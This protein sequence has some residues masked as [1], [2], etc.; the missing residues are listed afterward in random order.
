M[1]KHATA[2]LCVVL[3]G[4]SLAQQT[5]KELLRNIPGGFMNTG[6]Y[7]DLPP[8]EQY[9]YAM[10]FV[11]GMMASGN[12]GADISKLETLN[13][14]T[15]GMQAKQ[16]AAVLDKYVKEHPEVWHQTLAAHSL[17]AIIEA[18]PDLKK[19]MAAHP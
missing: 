1:L 3:L 12:L 5:G 19:Q 18:C 2:S 14:C 9:G 17:A 11:N 6:E 15:E 13:G 10:G 4:T 7:S 8:V 16:L